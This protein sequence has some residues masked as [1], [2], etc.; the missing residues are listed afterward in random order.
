MSCFTVIISYKSYFALMETH[1]ALRNYRFSQISHQLIVFYSVSELLRAGDSETRLHDGQ[2]GCYYSSKRFV[3]M[4]V[5]RENSYSPSESFEYKALQSAA[6]TGSI[7]Q[8]RYLIQNG[9]ELNSGPDPALHL[10]LRKQHIQ[11]ARLLLQAGAEHE[12]RDSK[13]DYPIHI[14]CTLGLVDIV[15]VLCTLG[16]NLEVSNTK[17]L[18]PLHLA[19]K[20]GHIHVVRYLCSAGCNVDVRNA[21]NIRA[22]ITA[23]KYGHNNIS[24]LLDRL[25]ATG[26]RDAFARQLVPTTKSSVTPSLRLLG[27]CGIGKTS[28]MKSLSAGLFSTL[29]K[30]S[31]SL[32]SNKSRP[33]SPINGQ[34]EMDVTSRQNSLSFESSANYQSTSGIQVRTLDISGVNE[35]S[36]WDFSGQENYFP[37]YHHFL[38]PNPHCLTAVLFSL[39]DPPSVQVQ[40]V[41]FWL[42]FLMARQPAD[43]PS[44]DM[45]SKIY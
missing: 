26:Q 3:D 17:G 36:V 41:S 40:Q 23:L 25:R 5:S 10:A 33:S 34:I 35:V 11:I 30:R 8:I 24:E 39:D 2:C 27:N 14:A 43:C 38:L 44:G 45:A 4:S 6:A 31:S 22:D 1:S 32:H 18:Y 12:C 13:G 15:R 28:V 29:F 20:Y 37:L 21:D 9:T 16:C 7:E 19:S 42:N